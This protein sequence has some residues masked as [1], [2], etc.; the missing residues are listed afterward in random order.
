[1]RSGKYFMMNLSFLSSCPFHPNECV[2]EQSMIDSK[3]EMWNIST[4][5]AEEEK[6]GK[7]DRQFL[8]KM[9]SSL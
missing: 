8:T 4:D 5:M 7:N 9:V 3:R 6:E 2:Q 1:M